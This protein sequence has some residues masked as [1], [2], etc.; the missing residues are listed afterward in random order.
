MTQLAS[1]CQLLPFFSK[2]HDEQYNSFSNVRRL[3]NGAG[4][5]SASHFSLDSSGV[6]KVSKSSSCADGRYSKKKVLEMAALAIVCVVVWCLYALP[7]IFYHIPV[8]LDEDVS[9]G[10]TPRARLLNHW[11]TKPEVCNQLVL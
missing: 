5:S 7:I 6:D 9:I 10:Y 3:T 8:E 11:A 2:M 1:F 4:A